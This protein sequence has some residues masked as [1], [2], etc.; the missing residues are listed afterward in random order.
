[1]A[2]R[3]LSPVR[4]GCSA[5][6]IARVRGDPRRRPGG[7]RRRA[8]VRPTD[9]GEVAVV[10]VAWDHDASAGAAPCCRKLARLILSGSSR[11]R[12]PPRGHHHIQK[13]TAIGRREVIIS[14]TCSPT[15][16][17]EARVGGV[18][19][20]DDGGARLP[21]GRV[22]TAGRTGA[23]SGVSRSAA[24]VRRTFNL[25]PTLRAG[26]ELLRTP[27]LMPRRG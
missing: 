16:P 18:I 5:P 24:E 3:V 15:H 26:E 20:A 13:M 19:D 4:S 1:M 22:R 12:A 17:A 14:P 9:S 23:I 11:L 8:A 2:S 6:S 10:A 25:G 27:G 7:S 21:R